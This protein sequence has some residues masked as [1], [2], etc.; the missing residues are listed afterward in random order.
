[1]FKK[2]F[3]F[4]SSIYYINIVGS[5]G[6][7]LILIMAMSSEIWSNPILPTQNESPFYFEDKMKRCGHCRKQKD[8][9]EFYKDCSTKDMLR[10]K[11]KSCDSILKKIYYNNNAEK[12]NEESKNYYKTH[13]K[14]RRKYNRE[15][16]KIYVKAHQKEI[17]LYQKI[18]F[19]NLRKHNLQFRLSRNIST[20]IRTA[21]RGNK[22]GQ[23]WE[24]LVGYSVEYL[25][26]HL[27]KQFTE[28]MC[29]DKFLKGEIHIDHR[30]PISAYNFKTYT[31]IDFQRCFALSNLQPMWAKDNL[32][33]QAKLEKDFQPSFAF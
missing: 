25:K 2:K 32:K 28:G 10:N 12:L 9:N 27:E 22:N 14:D 19:R 5:I 16:R 3:D 15:Y 29:W 1:M 6:F 11:C 26:K 4:L 13:I 17:S 30:I 7:F 8:E 20:G 18:Y 33:K 24:S 21:L 23:H 31:D